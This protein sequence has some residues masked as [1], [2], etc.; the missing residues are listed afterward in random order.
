MY[1]H[2]LF[3]LTLLAVL[4]TTACAQK[5]SNIIRMDPALDALVPAGAKVEKVAGGFGFIEGPLWAKEGYLL[6][7]DIP[8]S[9]VYKWMPKGDT[10]V[11]V[12]PSG[13]SN[14][15]TYDKQ[16]RLYLAQHEDRRIARLDKDGKQTTIV[17]KYQGKRL[18][19][20]ND[21]VMSKSGAI[22]FTDPP[23]G[24]A[25]TDDDPAKELSFNG[26]FVFNNN[27]LLV[28]DST[29]FRPNGIA[30]SPD[31]KY[32][33]VGEF[34]GKKEVWLQY[35]VKKDGTVANKKVL[36]DASSH[37]VRGNPDGMKV[38][39]KGNLYC[40]GPGGL[41]ILSPKGKALGLIEL[42][43]LPANCA[44]GDADSKT[45]Y[46]TSRTGLYRIKLAATGVRP[47]VQ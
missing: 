47:G 9:K 27:K 21:L 26:L 1:R 41:W 6:F 3:L 38:D 16:G 23:W 43:E 18:N 22:Y 42:P 37:S 2:I 35:D 36:F 7:S 20:P 12:Y 5:E 13:K 25:K 14:G 17:D 24:L 28:L 11:F 29:L 33:Y 10:S 31:E 39:T 4:T 8:R 19:S 44:W 15:L 46:M 40:T 45:L 32:L 34:D 30:L